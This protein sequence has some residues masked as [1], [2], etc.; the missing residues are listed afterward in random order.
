M[1]ENIIVYICD[2]NADFVKGVIERVRFELNYK[3]RT[4]E[5]IS[6]SDAENLIKTF[7]HRKADVVFLDIDMPL[8]TGFEAAAELQ[9]ADQ[10]ANIVFI[11]AHE[12]KVFQ[13]YEF[14][15]FWFV[16]KS[17]LESDLKIA[18]SRLLVKIDNDAA[19]ARRMFKIA[20]G[21]KLVDI[22]INNVMYIKSYKHYVIVK[23]QNHTEEQY[24]CKIQD[25]EPQLA[26]LGYIRIQ[27]G[28]LINCRFIARITS[29]HVILQ[30]DESFNI[31]RDRLEK[32]R[33]EY[34]KF[35]RSK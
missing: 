17:H 25:I 24:R 4:P 13:S 16:R 3:L 6:F 9:K 18:L 5:I 26:P 27:I 28:V 14:H 23:H 29:R 19:E 12:D 2:D 8:V 1:K 35:V 32:A 15:P 11:T 21:N 31:S 30:N 10:N 7:L 22:D 33:N 20:F 34:Q